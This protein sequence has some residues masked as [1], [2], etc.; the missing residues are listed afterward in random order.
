SPQMRRTLLAVGIAVLVSMLFTPHKTYWQS[1]GRVFYVHLAEQERDVRQTSSG[2]W[3]WKND[4]VPDWC[5]MWRWFPIFWIE[6]RNPILWPS[7]AGQTAFL[8]V[9]AG[10]LVNLR[11]QPKR[12]KEAR[13]PS[14]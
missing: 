11:K 4:Y 13:T 14:T 2:Q 3:V 8:A 10:V 1:L 7:F 9:L 5:R 6:D 12:E